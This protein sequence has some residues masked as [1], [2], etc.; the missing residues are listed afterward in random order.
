MNVPT[1]RRGDTGADV[2]TLQQR[3]NRAGGA[4]AIDGHFGPTTETAVR[5]FQSDRSMI[6]DGIVG[7]RTQAALLGQD[8]SAKALTEADVERAAQALGCD[9]AAI[10]AILEV[11]APRGGF[12]PDGRVTIL[13]ERHIMA[14]QLQAAGIDPAPFIASHPGIVNTTPGGYIGGAAE[15]QRL[16]RAKAINADCALESASW[17]RMQVMGFHW[18]ALGY[19]SVQA[20]VD[21][22]ASGEAAQLRVGVKLIEADEAMHTALVAHDWPAFAKTYNGPAYADYGYDLR[23]A[24]AYRRYPAAVPAPV[25][26]EP[27]LRRKR[28]TADA[29]SD[30]PAPDAPSAGSEA[31]T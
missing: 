19:A 28:K 18:Q 7:A 24:A 12:L 30:P 29:V 25:P 6:A 27:P 20:F 22:M 15:Y 16:A 9:A 31:I 2:T 10:H 1:L 4:V 8:V 11:E 21:D 23:L 17:G 5:A 13:F 14:R 26:V 3:L